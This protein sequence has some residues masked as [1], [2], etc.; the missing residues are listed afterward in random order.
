MHSVFCTSTI[1]ETDGST[2]ASASTARI[3]SKNDPP[4]PPNSSGISIPIN[5]NSNNCL[6][7]PPSISCASSIPRTNGAICSCAN[8]CTVR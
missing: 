7:S 4:A 6:T 1:T 2:E 3:A 5:P 8:S